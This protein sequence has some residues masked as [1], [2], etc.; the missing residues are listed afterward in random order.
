MRLHNGARVYLYQLLFAS[1][2]LIASQ[3]FG[4][5]NLQLLVAYVLISIAGYI[6][7]NLCDR[8]SDVSEKNPLTAGHIAPVFAWLWTLCLSM[9][10]VVVIV[11][12]DLTFLPFHIVYST[13]WF[14]YN[15]SVGGFRFKESILGPAVASFLLVAGYPLLLVIDSG[16]IPWLTWFSVALYGLSA[17]IGHTTKDEKQDKL[18]NIRTYAVRIGST[19][20]VNH[21][22]LLLVLSTALYIISIG[23]SYGLD[24]VATFLVLALILLKLNNYHKQWRAEFSYIWYCRVAAIHLATAIVI[25]YIELTGVAML[26][27]GVFLLSFS[28]LRTI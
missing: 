9:L 25:G 20:A 6:H 14:L 28:K 10:S 21:A 24:I 26:V 16:F 23:I 11:I 22:N 15:Q 17:E 18:S 3:Q 19:V 12:V 4:S 27:Y 2:I 1:L 5:R 8:Y 7:N 13:M